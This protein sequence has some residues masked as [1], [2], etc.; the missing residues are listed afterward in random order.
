MSVS[1]ITCPACGDTL[2]P[3][4]LAATMMHVL[5]HVNE[6]KYY[7]Q[8]IHDRPLK[9]SGWRSGQIPDKPSQR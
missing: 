2:Y 9:D 3:G 1:I 7:L 4:D 6:L 8:D 5:E